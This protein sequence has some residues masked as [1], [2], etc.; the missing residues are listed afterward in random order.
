[1]VCAIERLPQPRWT[2]N[3]DYFDLVKC[4]SIY[5]RWKLFTST[6]RG[7]ECFD[8]YDL[9]RQPNHCLWNKELFLP[10]IHPTGRQQ[11][12]RISSMN[13]TDLSSLNP[14]VN[15]LPLPSTL[16]TSQPTSRPTNPPSTSPSE[17]FREGGGLVTLHRS[18]EPF[19]STQAVTPH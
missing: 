15:P 14:T 16:P 13:P 10:F 7:L 6:S 19:I 12:Y 4:N 8:G 11:H 17:K 2:F 5:A 1:M 3:A 18:S 9:F